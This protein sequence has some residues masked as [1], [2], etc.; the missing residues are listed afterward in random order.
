MYVQLYQ[1]LSKRYESVQSMSVR[2]T[3]TETLV[4]SLTPQLVQARLEDKIGTLQVSLKSLSDGAAASASTISGLTTANE[5][6]QT[7]LASAEGKLTTL[8]GTKKAP[9]TYCVYCEHSQK[10]GKGGS[11]PWSI[12]YL[13]S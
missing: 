12:F 10:G 13:L 1:C 7:R 3:P 5:A 11:L 8:P 9:A 6:L 4:P 2:V